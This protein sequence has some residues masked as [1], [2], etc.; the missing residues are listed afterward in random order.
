MNYLKFTQYA[1]LLAAI[2]IAIEGYNQYRAGDNSKAILMAIFALIG[3]FMFFFRRSYAKKFAERN[4][5]P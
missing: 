4:K 5:K 2:L 3:I 1:Y